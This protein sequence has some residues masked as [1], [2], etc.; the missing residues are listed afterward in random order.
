MKNKLTSKEAFSLSMFISFPFYFLLLLFFTTVAKDK[1]T[2]SIRALL[3]V[4]SSLG[5]LNVLFSIK[6][7]KYYYQIQRLQL[8]SF[9]LCMVM[10]LLAS[11]LFTLPNKTS[12]TV[13]VVGGYLT[14]L[15]FIVRNLVR[16]PDKWDLARRQ[17]VLRDV[18][19]EESWTYK[20]EIPN[21]IDE[22]FLSTTAKQKSV[23]LITRLEKLH[24]LMPAIGMALSRSFPDQRTF[25][26]LISCL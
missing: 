26:M 9:S 5:F 4:I 15:F 10:F 12:A 24:Y 8:I 2:Q 17:G 22:V 25:L 23:R 21:S 3:F 7:I 1:A 6:R 11:V 13:W 14:S 18:L 20:F 19:D 16:E